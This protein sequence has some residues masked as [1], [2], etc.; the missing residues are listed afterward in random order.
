MGF[1]MLNFPLL[2]SLHSILGLTITVCNQDFSIIR[3]YKS[4]KTLSLLYNHYHILSGFNNTQYDFLFHYGF[5]GELFLAHHVQQYYIIIGPW[6]S[7]AINSLSLKEKLSENQL[8]VSEQDYFVEKFSQLPF[9]SL[10]QIRE[11]LMLTNYCV[12]GIVEDK[13]SEPLH[14]YT[15]GWSNSFELEKVLSFAT[16]NT[17]SYKYQYQFE[18]NILKAV[19]SGDE[20][21]LRKTVEKFSNAITPTLSEDELRSEKNYSMMVYALLSQASILIGLDIETAYQA[22]DRFIR[23]TES[24]VSLNDVLKLRDTAILFYTQQIHCFKTQITSPHSHIVI[25]VIQYLKNNL[26]RFIKTEEIAKEFHLSES[27]LRK[28]F[29]QEKHITI[30]QYFLNLKIEMAKQLLCE[31]KKVEEIADLLGFSTSSNF[32]RTFKKIEGIPPLEF[33][34]KR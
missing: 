12:T 18:N 17:S 24:A 7:N 16:E 3:E 33:K 5:L 15:K 29:K 30:Q 4:D 19:K 28:I 34:L 14:Y 25:N 23:K 32:S 22:R 8:K 26:N 11:L 9:F 21:L 27:K 1:F 10:S 31:D 13:L 6:R 20:L 2:K